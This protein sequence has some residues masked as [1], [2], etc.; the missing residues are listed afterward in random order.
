MSFLQPWG[1]LPK[2]AFFHSSSFSICSMSCFNLGT[3]DWVI[4]LNL[5]EINA[6][7]V[8]NQHVAKRGNLAP[9]D[10]RPSGLQRVGQELAAFRK[11]LEIPKH[12]EFPASVRDGGGTRLIAYAEGGRARHGIPSSGASR[13]C[14]AV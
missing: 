3:S 11:H 10:L 12:C 14:G 7:I 13:G 9:F 8:M 1:G 4:F 6:Q 2:A 5:L